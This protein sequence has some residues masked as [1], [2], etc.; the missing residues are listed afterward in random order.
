MPYR[1]RRLLGLTLARRAG[2]GG[3][4]KKE[5]KKKDKKKKKDDSE[6]RCE[7]RRGTGAWRSRCFGME[8]AVRRGGKGGG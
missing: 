4:E 1:R 6:D 8:H 2:E 5:K 7:P 3:E